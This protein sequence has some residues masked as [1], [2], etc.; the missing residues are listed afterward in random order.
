MPQV[1]ATYALGGRPVAESAAGVATC[2]TDLTLALPAGASITGVDISY[3]INAWG[4]GYRSEQQSRVV[5]PTLSRGETAWTAGFGDWDGVMEYGRYGVSVFNGTA[6]GNIVFRLEA[7]R[8]WSSDG[9]APCSSL[10]HV[11]TNNTYSITV[12]YET[13]AEAAEAQIRAHA[14]I[15]QISLLA[16]SEIAAGRLSLD[17]LFG[18]ARL[19]SAQSNARIHLDGLFQPLSFRGR[20]FPP[21]QK[22][23]PRA[24]R[25]TAACS[26]AHPM[27]ALM[28]CCRSGRFR[29]GTGGIRHLTIRS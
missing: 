20:A 15:S 3:E 4:S 7:Y 1:S 28:P 25:S 13:S 19:L 18:E 21:T 29:S 5:S 14:L 24:S 11:I 10:N 17:H 6:A 26:P 23:Q 8:T 27:A 16:E 2:Y 12:Y 22:P 9:E